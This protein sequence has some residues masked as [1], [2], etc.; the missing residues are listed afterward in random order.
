MF[1]A[2]IKDSY[3]TATARTRSR[4]SLAKGAKSIK[5]RVNNLN[6]GYLESVMAH[7]F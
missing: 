6:S 5:N 1:K 3:Y 7:L 4:A 2:L